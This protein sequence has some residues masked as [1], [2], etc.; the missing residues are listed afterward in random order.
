M[1]PQAE[2]LTLSA[3]SP[4]TLK[5]VGDSQTKIRWLHNGMAL[6]MNG[7]VIITTAKNTDDHTVRSI[8]TRMAM[9]PREQV[10]YI[11]QDAEDPF[12]KDQVKVTVTDQSN[13][14]SK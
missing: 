9:T 12:N 7:Q 2:T 8:F 6:S 3:G 14:G 10:N 5:C 11:C 1:E 13:S 4:L